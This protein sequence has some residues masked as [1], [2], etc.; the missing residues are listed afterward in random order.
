MNIDIAGLTQGFEIDPNQQF[1]RD[2]DT[3]ITQL[4]N[5]EQVARDLYGND[6]P[7]NYVEE[8]KQYCLLDRFVMKLER[9]EPIDLRNMLSELLMQDTMAMII[10]HFE[11]NS[12]KANVKNFDGAY[13][14]M[15]VTECQFTFGQIYAFVER[16]KTRFNILEYGC[17]LSS[18]EEVFNSHASEAMYMALNKRLEFRRK[19]TIRSLQD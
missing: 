7:L 9:G 4:R 10:A 2:K 11:Q 18:L 14:Q 16:M 12:M 15:E 5:W 17:K 13:V 19:S 6:R 1:V 8:F 3:V